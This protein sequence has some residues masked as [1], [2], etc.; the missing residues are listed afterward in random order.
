MKRNY[1]S[2]DSSISTM[3]PSDF[4]ALQQKENTLSK[5]LIEK[6]EDKT[7]KIS[8]AFNTQVLFNYIFS[9]MFKKPKSYIIGIFTVS[10]TVA[11][12]A[13]IYNILDVSPVIFLKLAQDQVG[14]SDFI[15]HAKAGQNISESG[16][17]FIYGHDLDRKV[18]PPIVWPLVNTT[19]LQLKT[20]NSTYYNGFTPRWFGLF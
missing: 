14:E 17:K 15:F 20:E 4:D 18:P 8:S 12:F 10:I 5:P 7:I 16:D 19:D 2:P 1:G 9:D 13:I 3:N 11:F 6:K